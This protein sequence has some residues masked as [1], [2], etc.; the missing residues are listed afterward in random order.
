MGRYKFTWV[1]PLTFILGSFLTPVT[2]AESISYGPAARFFVD[3]PLS[4]LELIN[5]S[6]RMDMLDYYAADSIYH[7]PN[8]MEG[9]SYLE[10]VTPVYVKLSLTPVS[11]MSVSVLPL[12][13]DT[14][15]QCIYTLGSD[16]QAHDSEIKLYDRNYHELP[17][18]KFITLPELNDFFNIPSKGKKEKI[19]L[20]EQI[21][22]FPTVTYTFDPD[23]YVL[24]ARLT[25]EEIIGKDEY[26]K[27]SYLL[28][29]EIKY[30]WNGKRYELQ[31]SLK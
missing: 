15:Y 19:S 30:I 22:P 7:A 4:V 11:T 16:T 13:K 23:S 2:R 14:I 9:F 18:N 27:I 24:T 17:V 1:L 21:I 29:P 6:N 12:K 28:K 3:M 26:E 20:I 25:S 5:R 10:K 31:K 8:G